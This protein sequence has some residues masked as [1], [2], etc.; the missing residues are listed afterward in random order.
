M[1]IENVLRVSAALHGSRAAIVAGKVAHSY[2]ELDRKSDRLAAALS[3]RGVGSGDGVA[4]FLAPG[5]PSVVAAFAILKAGGVI[6]P[7]D[8]RATADALAGV[9]SHRATFAMVTE[10][11]LALKAA[12][13]ICSAPPVRLIVLAGGDHLALAR[14]CISF[15]DAVGRDQLAALPP[16][17]ED[18]DI[19]IRLPAAGGESDVT[20]S[21]AEVLEMIS[22]SETLPEKL[23]VG[24]VADYCRLISAIQAGVTKVIDAPAEVPLPARKDARDLQLALNL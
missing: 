22:G 12:A 15:D 5:F 7:V 11:R 4:V 20:F 8:A 3:E 24:P 1:R 13:A 16:Q 2:T 10:A 14:N 17:D 18:H 6:C 21:H 9:L 19:A 23:F